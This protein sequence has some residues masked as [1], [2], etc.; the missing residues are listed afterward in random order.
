MNI[1]WT[2][3]LGRKSIPTTDSSKELFPLLWVPKVTIL[4]N[5]ICFYNPTS[6]KLSITEINF[7]KLE[8][9]DFDSIF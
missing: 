3:P 4:G 1:N 7:L 5:L 9:N 2:S 6:L 8:Y